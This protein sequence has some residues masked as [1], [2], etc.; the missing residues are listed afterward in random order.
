MVTVGADNGVQFTY[1]LTW[2]VIAF[3]IALAILQI[4]SVNHGLSK[5]DVVYFLPIYNCYL[6]LWSIIVG[7][8]YFD[9][10]S[11]LG[12]KQ[13]SMFCL[14]S[15]ICATGILLEFMSLSLTA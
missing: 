3:A 12:A 11:G 10:A 2:V 6:M 14:G 15:L 7:T 1:G 4:K 9:E 5:F 13:I 8:I